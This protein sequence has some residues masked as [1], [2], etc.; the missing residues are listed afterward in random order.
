MGK[1]S[2][3]ALHLGA[4]DVAVEMVECGLVLPVIEAATERWARHV[5]ELGRHCGDHSDILVEAGA[6]QALQKALE[7]GTRY[8][9]YERLG[10][11]EEGEYPNESQKV[12][13]LN[14]GTVHEVWE[15]CKPR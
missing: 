8:R 12:G 15:Q 4:L 2:S 10:D 7:V 6:T 14:P 11:R 3:E 9:T 1:G 13:Q 5:G